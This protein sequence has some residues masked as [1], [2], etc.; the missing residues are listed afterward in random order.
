MNKEQ[1]K[2]IKNNEFNIA[3][4]GRGILKQ[5][6][7]EL[8]QK[9]ILLQHQLEE[10][11]KVIDE[12]ID[13]IKNTKNYVFDAKRSKITGELIVNN[14]IETNAINKIKLLEILERGKNGK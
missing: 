4:G 9:N 8:Q 7:A 5:K 2:Y 3:F 14:K 6:F 13:Y 12:A 11:N 10:K 1:K